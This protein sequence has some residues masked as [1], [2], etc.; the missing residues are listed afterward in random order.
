MQRKRRFSS[1]QVI[2]SLDDHLYE[3]TSEMSRLLIIGL[4]AVCFSTII[5]CET[6]FIDFSPTFFRYYSNVKGIG[7][8]TFWS[9]TFSYIET[10]FEV[11][12]RIGTIYVSLL[13]L[14]EIGTQF[15]EGPFLEDNPEVLLYYC[16][17]LASYF[18]I[19]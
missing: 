5:V 9:A 6:A 7:I 3:E 8:A 17:S 4:G 15:I 14:L 13:G 2:D 10:Y 19:L 16:T 18:K 11:T 1:F 12:D